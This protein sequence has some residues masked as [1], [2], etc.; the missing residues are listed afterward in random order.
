MQTTVSSRVFLQ[1][2]RHALAG[3]T[4]ADRIK[5][6]TKFVGNAATRKDQ[7]LNVV[8]GIVL[9]GFPRELRRNWDTWSKELI[10]RGWPALASWGV[11][12][13]TDDD[14]TALTAVEKG[15][16]IG[17]ILALSSCSAGLIDAEGQYDSDKGPE[18]E[19]DESGALR[20]MSKIR[21]IAPTKPLGDQ[22]WFAIDSHGELRKTPKPIEAGGVF[23][24]FP[25]DEFAKDINWARFR[26]AYLNNFTRQLGD[27]RY[28][29]IFDWMD[30]DW[31]RITPAL[32]SAGLERTL[33]L[34]IQGYGWRLHDLVHC[35]LREIA[36]RKNEIIIWCDAL[37]DETTLQALRIVSALLKGGFV[38][39]GASPEDIVRRFQEAYN[40]SDVKKK[41]LV[42]DGLAGPEVYSVIR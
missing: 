29:R 12:G 35:I 25:V 9:H 30:R 27:R 11:D 41:T 2:Y 21:S 5:T 28:K 19:T 42:V 15:E 22:P 36:T 10:D 8:G 20:M 39:E 38:V 1:I 40:A 4:Q 17:E 31:G 24:G 6:L 18:D 7:A 32:R 14:G 34:T 37:P 16:C 3:R 33:A 26:Q 23:A 13:Q